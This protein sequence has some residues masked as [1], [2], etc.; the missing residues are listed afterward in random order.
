[1]QNFALRPEIRAK[2]DNMETLLALCTL[3]VGACFCPEDLARACLSRSR[4][5][6]L[7]VIRLGEDACYPIR[8]GHLK[9]SYQWNIRSEFI[10]IAEQTYCPVPSETV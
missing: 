7:R 4:M 5:E 9:Q 8:F 1:M 3:G 10:R 2:S 6:G